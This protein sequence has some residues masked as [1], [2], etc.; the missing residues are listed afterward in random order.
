MTNALEQ[1]LLPT[2]MTDLLPGDAAFEAGAVERLMACFASHGFER[3]KPPLLEFE[4]SLL[5]GSGAAMASQTFRLMDPVSQRMMGLRADMTLQ[6]A[7]IATSRLKNAPRP[8]KLSYAGEVLRVKGSQLRP[9]RQFGQVGAELI[10]SADPAADAE[11]ILMAVDALATVGVP[12]ISVDIALPTLVPALC[13]PANLDSSTRAHLRAA[14]DRKDSAGVTQLKGRLGDS[15]TAALTGLLMAMGPAASAL[16]AFDRLALKGEAKVAWGALKE[17]VARVSG[18]AP[19]LTLTIDPV[20]NRGFEYHTG[21]TFT[22]FAKGVRG[23]L[24]SGGRYQ[25]GNGTGEPATG[26]TLFMDTV[27]QALP[28]GKPKPRVFLPLGTAAADGHRLR[29]DGWITVQGLAER[30][31]AEAEA[32]RFKCG[33]VWLAGRLQALGS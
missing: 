5:S 22:F 25:A 14:L 30:S 33:H 19:S 24:G 4:E 20:E 26:L 27:L 29:A 17:V 15:L 32:R 7:R 11:V 9:E 13:R 21:V 18:A 6:V 12:A 31:G 2:G 28:P 8:L 23:E 1:G 16:A 10:G 3:V